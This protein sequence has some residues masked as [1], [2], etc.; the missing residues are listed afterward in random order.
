MHTCGNAH[1]CTS[2]TTWSKLHLE[3]ED[4]YLVLNE[5]AEA[6]LFLTFLTSF[7]TWL[8]E[9]LPIKQ[10]FW[11]YRVLL[12]YFCSLNNVKS[13]TGE[14]NDK[15]ITC[16]LKKLSKNYPKKDLSSHKWNLSSHHPL[17]ALIDLFCKPRL[18]SGKLAHSFIPHPP[19]YLLAHPSHCPAHIL[20]LPCFLYSFFVDLFFSLGPSTSR[21]LSPARLSVFP[22]NYPDFT[23]EGCGKKGMCGGGGGWADWQSADKQVISPH[24]YSSLEDQRSKS[25]WNLERRPNVISCSRLLATFHANFVRTISDILSYFADRQTE[26]HLQSHDPPW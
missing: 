21:T 23:T 26:R 19:L 17:T 12:M 10:R 14:S 5:G 4:S 11:R 15:V 20:F 2:D 25:V 22:I 6:G 16:L 7:N 8:P 3:T 9:I 18:L 24:I 1:V 13:M